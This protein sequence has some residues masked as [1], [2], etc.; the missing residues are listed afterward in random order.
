MTLLP[1]LFGAIRT[2]DAEAARR[3][4]DPNPGLA[5]ARGE[6]GESPVMMALYHGADEVLSLLIEFGAE[7]DVFAAAAAGRGERPEAILDADPRQLD[8]FAADGWTALHLAAFFGQTAAAGALL[9]RGADVGA[10]SRNA[11]ANMPL[12]AALA[13]RMERRL[14]ELLLA[15]GADVN[16]RGGAGYTPLHLAASRGDAGLVEL[17]LAHGGRPGSSSDDGRTA[18]D[19][20]GER[21][22]PEVAVLLR[23]RGGGTP[24]E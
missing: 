12:H 15:H 1:Q 19:I 8:A 3:L 14:V 9:A 2:R 22:Y 23:Q 13:G 6:G 5:S 7:L 24:A 10:V 20:A 4:L 18:A 11:T 17:L 16:A 21:G